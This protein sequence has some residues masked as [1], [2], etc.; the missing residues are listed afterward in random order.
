MIRTYIQI[1]KFMATLYDVEVHTINYHIKKIFSDSELEES[2][3]IRKFRITAS[4]KKRMLIRVLLIVM[5]N[6]GKQ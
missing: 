2:L 5:K 1:Q 6:K 3:V 4:D